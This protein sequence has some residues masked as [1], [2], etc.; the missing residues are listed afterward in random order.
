MPQSNHHNRN[1][2]FSILRRWLLISIVFL[3]WIGVALI[4]WFYFPQLADSILIPP[5]ATQ[6]SPTAT[7]LLPT[8]TP[9]S[10]VPFEV[11]AA[12]GWQDTG[13]YVNSGDQVEIIY[14][15]GL[16]T[17]KSGLKNYT[18]PAGGK[19]SQDNPCYP[20]SHNE[21]GYN[22]LI[23]KIWYGNPFLVGQHFTGKTLIAGT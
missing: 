16:W 13:V 11:F 7:Q 20:M 10:S 4:I 23:G 12:K 17:G 6:L 8:S 21:T 2:G 19:P 3:L 18:G 5:T 1:G 22:A 9:Y 14:V 15:K